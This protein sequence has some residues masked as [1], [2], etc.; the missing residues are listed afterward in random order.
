MGSSFGHVGSARVGSC[1]QLVLTPTR[2][3]VP[4]DSGRVQRNRN[5]NY[6]A[7][8]TAS[9]LVSWITASPSLQLRLMTRP[10]ASRT[11]QSHDHFHSPRQ[12]PNG[13]R[14]S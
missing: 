7:T 1:G 14:T 6:N 3:V 5:D 8:A 13:K 9:K 11:T 10:C 2:P 12:R 4:F